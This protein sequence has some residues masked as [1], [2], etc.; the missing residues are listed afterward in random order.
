V[1]E[2]ATTRRDILRKTAGVAAVTGS[3][4]LSSSPIPDFSIELAVT[5]DLADLSEEEEYARDYTLQLVENWIDRAVRPMLEENYDVS[6]DYLETEPNVSG[7][8]E[9]ALHEWRQLSDINKSCSLLVTGE[10]YG[11]RVGLAE[12]VDRPMESSAA[13]VGE[14][15]DLLELEE[16][17][18]REQL[19]EVE[20]SF[21]EREENNTP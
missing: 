2:E 21:L 10:K 8:P 19:P 9:E 1:A 18:W 4:A 15:Y 20:L 16:E 13:I 5:E 14:G 11:E 12:K 17:E 3:I 7:D 6:T